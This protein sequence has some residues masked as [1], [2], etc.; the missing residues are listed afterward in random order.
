MDRCGRGDRGEVRRGPFGK[1]GRY[2][3]HEG[4]GGDPGFDRF[5]AFV[6]KYNI[7]R[8]LIIS[9][10]IK[11]GLLRNKSVFFLIKGV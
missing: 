10:K 2:P 9:D 3:D 7:K 5:K 1:G 8:N 4:P 6:Y 11:Q